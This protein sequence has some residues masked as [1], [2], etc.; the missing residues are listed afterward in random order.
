MRLV[1]PT[2]NLL[3]GTKAFDARDEDGISLDPTTYP[4][5]WSSTNST[6]SVNSEK[7]VHPRQYSLKVQ[8]VNQNSPIVL[9]ISG[10][11]PI[12]TEMN[13]SRAQFHAQIYATTELNA[14]AKLI[15]VP[16][17]TFATYAQDVVSS[18]WSPIWSPELEVG[19]VDLSNDTIEFN[20]E[21]TITNHAGQVFYMSVPTIM[22]ALGFIKNTFVANMRKFIPT[23]IWDKDKI[24][25]YPNY[26]FTKLMDIL[27][28]KG[29]YSTILYTRFYN[30][31]NSQ[32]TVSSLDEDYRYSILIDPEHVDPDYQDWLS[33]FNGTRLYQ[34]ITS[35][36][37]LEVLDTNNI[38]DSITWQLT[39]G[40]FGR[41]AGT[42]EAIRECAKQILT[43]NK[44]VHVFSGGSFFQINVYTLLSETPGVTVSG[45]TSPQVEAI[46]NKAK[47]MGFVLNHEAYSALPLI[48][49]SSV[50]AVLGTASLG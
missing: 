19:L 24:Q 28:R 32:L 38:D 44:V 18:V 27:T 48:L 4:I 11:S 50:Y 20:V 33:Q 10:V 6:V 35:S 31:F 15:N 23:F 43:G 5:S 26:P 8:P 7:Y 22:N 16:A 34:S 45:D 37:S 36:N 1:N 29:D 9:S 3:S 39:N 13:N 46:I 25:E 2:R 30:Y 14:S 21:I 41:N 49:D 47:P 12:L 40:Y 17:N 42:V